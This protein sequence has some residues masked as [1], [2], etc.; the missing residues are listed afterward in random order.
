MEEVKKKFAKEK[1]Y[2]SFECSW[3]VQ[4]GDMRG[5]FKCLDTL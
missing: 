1:S 4:T 2:F 3:S 5:G